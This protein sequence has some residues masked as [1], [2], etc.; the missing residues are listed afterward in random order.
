MVVIFGITN[1]M[2][3]YFA[4]SEISRLTF[5][6]LWYSGAFI[7]TL[8]LLLLERSE[9]RKLFQRKIW[10]VPFASIGI[11]GAMAT[12]YWALQLAPA[13][14]VLPINQ[15]GAPLVAILSGWWVFKERKGLTRLE[16]AGFALGC[17]GIFFVVL[18]QNFS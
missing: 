1:F 13:G 16:L 10:K 9:H 15:F 7:G 3:K 17:I 8:P 2:L 6:S 11:F 14:V 5:F 12:I 18:S 4:L